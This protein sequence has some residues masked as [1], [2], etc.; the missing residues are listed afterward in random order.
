MNDF[1]HLA[2]LQVSDKK[3]KKFTFDGVKGEPYFMVLSATE[4]NKEYFNDALKQQRKNN[5][6]KMS[7]VSIKKARDR[8]RQLYPKHVIKDGGNLYDVKGDLIPFS[9]EVANQFLDQLPDHI[10]D[11]LREYCLEVEN[12]VDAEDEIEDLIKN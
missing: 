6:K 4:A 11:D 5:I 9:K 1:S 7:A 12:F 2:E 3:T 10:F 8:D